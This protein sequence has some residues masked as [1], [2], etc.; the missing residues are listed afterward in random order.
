MFIHPLGSEFMKKKQ[1]KK[2]E[3]TLRQQRQIPQLWTMNESVG[4]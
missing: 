3:E 1:V 2:K 4:D